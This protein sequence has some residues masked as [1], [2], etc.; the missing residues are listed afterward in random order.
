MAQ[1]LRA[2]AW[3]L[4]R[5]DNLQIRLCFVSE[6]L[7]DVCTHCN[8]ASTDGLRLENVSWTLT[9]FATAPEGEGARAELTECLLA[10]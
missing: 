8:E 5:Q 2:V 6:P 3:P 9:R 10:S 4:R 1:R 7:V